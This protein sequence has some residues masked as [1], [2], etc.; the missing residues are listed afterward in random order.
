MTPAFSGLRVIDTTHVLAGP[1]ASYQMAL[2]G[3]EV[4]KVESPND[5]DQARF[6]GADRDLVRKDMGAAFLSQ[7]A[8]KKAL[9]LDL[10]TEAGREALKR[11]AATADVFVENYRPGAFDA[12]GLGYA[13]LAAINPGLIYCS[14]SAFGST[15]PK[16][17]ATGYDNVIQ[18]YSGIMDVTGTGDGNPLK[19]GAPVIDYATGMTAAFAIAAALFQ[20]SQN[21]G[22]GQH[23]DVSMLEVALTL[24]TSH[25]TDYLHSGKHPKAKGNSYAFA[26]IGLYQASDAPLMV[27][28][29]NLRQQR[30][31]WIALG[32]EDLVKTNNFDRIDMAAEE[33]EALTEII[34]TMTADY[35]EAFLNE[36]RIPAARVRRMEEA[37][38]DPQTQ[39][40]GQVLRVADPAGHVDGLQILSSAFRMTGSATGTTLAPQA[41]GAQTVD[42]LR[43][44]GLTEAEIEAM[45]Q[46]GAAH[47]APT[48]RTEAAE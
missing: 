6:Q 3:A 34:A 43:E 47:Q 28:A 14:I 26:T 1:F 33:R 8:G 18:S 24:Q 20:R 29:S 10:K 27:A 12:L 31:L 32:R 37:L 5:P 21:G 45:L 2:L 13:D 35:W 40:R 17:T 16:R 44:A 46:S 23:I 22:K 41:V 36:R 19:C 7:S 48:A 11:L 15:G 39:A 25:V 42:L 30:R 38:N 9:A 4:I